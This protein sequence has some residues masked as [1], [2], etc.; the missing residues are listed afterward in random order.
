[1]QNTELVIKFFVQLMTI[2]IS[3][4]FVSYL[5]RRFL[6]QTN[7]VCEMLTGILL[8]PS[9]LGLFFPEFQQWLF[10][11]TPLSLASGGVIP[12]PSMSILYVTSQIG[13]VVFMFFVGMHFNTKIILN[14]IKSSGVI[15]LVGILFPFFLGFITI[16]LTP[17]T[18]IFFTED[19]SLH[20]RG[21]FL[22]I[23]LS[24][25]AFPMMA[26]ILEDSKLSKT[27]LGTVALSAGST[28]DL[29]A[30]ILMA[31]FIATVK[32]NINIFL[33]TFFGTLAYIIIL[34]LFR[35]KIF[36]TIFKY[37]HNI[38]KLFT[39]VMICLIFSS[40]FTEEIGIYLVFGSFLFGVIIP[41]GIWIEQISVRCYDFVCTIFL[42]LFFVYSGLNTKISLINS[43]SIFLFFIIALF[44]AIV[45]KGVGC[46]LA[47]RL[48][49]ETWRDSGV[50]GCLMN[51]RGLMELIALNIGLEHNIITPT[52][53]TVLVLVAVITT[54]MTTPLYCW[55]SGERIDSSS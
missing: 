54:L 13:L 24:I 15:S 19:V 42:P 4:Q 25:T 43:I 51:A 5:G 23:A 26:R 40:L 10:P 38:S 50:I 29:I 1:M 49:G 46:T 35:K 53:Y 6:M 33:C 41:R 11:S 14:T 20:F 47:A 2:M 7:V 8:G 37:E 12:N 18:S 21:F 44:I 9:C 48:S 16:L 3:C 31:A 34:F 36:Q 52:L 28:D 30:W 55:I 27:R 39:V 22:G 45:G 17:D 32:N